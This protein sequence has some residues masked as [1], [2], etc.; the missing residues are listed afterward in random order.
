MDRPASAAEGGPRS[1]TGTGT[2]AT[3]SPVPA[4]APKLAELADRRWTD[5]LD[6]ALRTAPAVRDH[7]VPLPRERGLLPEPARG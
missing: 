3:G 2:A 4:R 5:G 6:P 7:L 1:A